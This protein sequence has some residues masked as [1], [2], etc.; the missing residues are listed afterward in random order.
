MKFGK[1]AKGKKPR[2]EKEGFDEDC[3]GGNGNGE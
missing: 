1:L 2:E 3:N